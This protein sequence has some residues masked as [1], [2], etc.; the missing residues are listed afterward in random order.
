MGAVTWL[1]GWLV[2]LAVL[3][4]AMRAAYSIRLLAVKEYGMVIHE[5]DPWFNFR[6]T[7]YLVDHG[8]HAFTNWFDTEV[9]YPLGRHVGSTVYPGMMVTSAAIYR[10]LP[11]LGAPMSLNDI[12]VLVPAWFACA[13]TFFTFLLTYEVFRSGN[14]AVAAAAIFAILP[15]H[16]MRSIAGGYDNESIAVTVIAATFY[17]WVRSLRSNRSWPIGVLTGLSY[18]YMVATWGGYVFVL[19][20]IAL[21][22]GFLVLRGEHS[23]KLHRAYTL[24]YIIGT[25]GALQFPIVGTQ[26]LKSLEQLSGLAVFLL[27]QV[28]EFLRVIRKRQKMDDREFREFAIKVVGVCLVLALLLLFLLPGGFIGPL[29]ARVRGLFVPHTRTGNPLVDSVAEHQA[30]ASDAYA[31]HFH[32]TIFSW[33]P[34]FVLCLRNRTEAKTFLLV[35]FA[36]AAY[37]SRKMT[38]L[39]LLLATPSAVL[40]GGAFGLLIDWMIDATLSVVNP[41]ALEKEATK[42]AATKA[43]EKGKKKDKKKVVEGSLSDEVAQ[44]RED[45]LALYRTNPSLRAMLV[46]MAGLLVIFL[47]G[48]FWVH[49]WTMAGHMSHPQIMLKGT[50]RTGEQIIIDDFREAYWWLRDNTREDA[51][52]LSWWDYGYQINGVGNRTTL[53]D[54]NTWNHEHIA[55]LGKILVSPEKES[56]EIARHLA[57]YVLVWTTRWGGMAG[58]DIAK[59]PHMARIGSSVYEDIDFRSFWY[60]QQSGEVSPMMEESLLWRL[61]HFRLHPSVPTLTYYQEAHTT[62]HNMVRIYKIQ[63]R[64]RESKEFCREALEWARVHG[65]GGKYPPALEGLLEQRRDFTRHKEGKYLR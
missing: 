29:S 58:D 34:G 7:Q 52:V 23:A 57:D 43:A 18:V 40:A 11:R 60:N 61:H 5:F 45:V 41:E 39:L 36:T 19:N 13:A 51:R 20:L 32:L 35:Y 30:T 62:K 12:C 54:G 9:W 56:W 8:Y 63:N 48:A 3:G 59:S 22:A 1:A 28:A 47:A 42:A 6:A 33:I 31:R 49:A 65:G 53:A 37:F 2:R 50:T 15:A 16:L 55:L 44:F 26:P 4:I 64:S 38:R 17:L 27:L 24:F 25:A 46:A 10:L 14:A 21:H